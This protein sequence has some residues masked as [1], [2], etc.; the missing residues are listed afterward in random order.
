MSKTPSTVELVRT[1]PLQA[2]I[3]LDGLAALLCEAVNGGAS[4]SFLPPLDMATWRG[5]WRRVIEAIGEGTRILLV[6]RIDREVVGT[7]QLDIAT[8]PNQPHRADVAKLLV[9]RAL[10]RQGVARA[11]MA[12]IEQEARAIGR[13]LLTLDTRTGDAAEPLYK[14][15]GYTC[16]GQIPGYALNGA[17]TRD[18]TSI[19][20]KQL[21]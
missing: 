13:T 14:A 11:L 16:I 9:S 17:G 20:F 15:L 8:P 5:F 3:H 7:V 21:A 2:T 1:T 10:R 19:F 6:A 18:A 4:V 12:R